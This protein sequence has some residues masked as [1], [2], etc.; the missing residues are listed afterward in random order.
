MISGSDESNS[1]WLPIEIHIGATNESASA[2]RIVSAT[3]TCS[4]SRDRLSVSIS[5]TVVACSPSGTAM[6][7]RTPAAGGSGRS[8][9]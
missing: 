5:E 3:A 6:W 1:H 9:S 2:I 4:L 7:K 8:Q